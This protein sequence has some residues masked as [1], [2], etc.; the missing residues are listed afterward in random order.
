[1][2]VFFKMKQICCSGVLC[3]IKCKQGLGCGKIGTLGTVGENVKCSSCS[4]K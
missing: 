4:R 3:H 1:M 2:M